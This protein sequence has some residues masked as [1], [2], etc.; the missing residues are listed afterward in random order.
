MRHRLT[1]QIVLA[2]TSAPNSM[3]RP[4][5]PRYWIDGRVCRLLIIDTLTS[6]ADIFSILLES[7]RHANRNVYRTS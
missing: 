5:A 6:L 1:L 4:I 7:S 3:D 2:R